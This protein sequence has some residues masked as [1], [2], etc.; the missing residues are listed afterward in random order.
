MHSN[1]LIRDCS[2]SSSG[3]GVK[4]A[5]GGGGGRG[6]RYFFTVGQLHGTADP[7]VVVGAGVEGVRGGG[8]GRAADLEVHKAT[9]TITTECCR[10]E[11]GH[12]T[13][14]KIPAGTMKYITAKY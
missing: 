8:G 12:N 2:R 4:V 14:I 11:T 6:V 7:A 3:C 10:T 1:L 5:R 9:C 13:R